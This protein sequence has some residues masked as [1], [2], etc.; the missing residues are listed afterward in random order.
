MT[1]KYSLLLL[2]MLLHTKEAGAD[3]AAGGSWNGEDGLMFAGPASTREE[4]LAV[5]NDLMAPYLKQLMR[6]QGGFVLK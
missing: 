5:S 1:R 4:A 3:E 6:D 2:T